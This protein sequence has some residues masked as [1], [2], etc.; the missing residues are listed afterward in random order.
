MKTDHSFKPL[1]EKYMA[2]V[3]PAKVLEWG[4]GESTRII[5]EACP[6]AQIIT[7]EN[8][9]SF[10]RHACDE[11]RYAQVI[12][13]PIPDYGPSEYSCWPLIHTPDDKYDL[14][15][16]D[17]RQRVGCLVTSMSCLNEGGVII[18]HDAERIHYRHGIALFDVIE[19]TGCTVVLK[20]K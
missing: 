15:F 3:K 1:L 9:I 7:I 17:G 8:Q 18:M 11:H 14:I 2:I 10:Y 13:S 16:I 6:R 5:H 20:P 19:S 12:H 4:P